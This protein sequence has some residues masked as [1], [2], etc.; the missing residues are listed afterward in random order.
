M[1]KHICGATQLR[2]K[3]QLQLSTNTWQWRCHFTLWVSHPKN[4]SLQP[5]GDSGTC[6]D[7]HTHTHTPGNPP[8]AQS[9]VPSWYLA[10]TWRKTTQSDIFY[11]DS[12]RDAPSTLSLLEHKVW[13]HLKSSHSN[14]L[15]LRYS[16]FR[17]KTRCY[18]KRWQRGCN[19]LPFDMHSSNRSH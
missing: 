6:R 7:K 12:P 15:V 10:L 11:R 18:C 3:T 14:I 2:N 4:P 16:M 17:R 5:G 8:V 1:G 19:Y 13:F 9:L